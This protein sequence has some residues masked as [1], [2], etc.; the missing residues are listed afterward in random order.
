MRRNVRTGVA[1]DILRLA[2]IGVWAAEPRDV[3]LLHVLFYIRSAGSIEILTDTEGGAQQD[4][5]VGGTQLISLRMAEELGDGRRRAR[6][7]RCG[8]SSPRR[9][10]AS[11]SRPATGS[12]SAPG[13]RSSP[14]PPTL[15]GRIAY[16]PPLP[17]VRD[18]LS[19]RMAQG[20][21]VKCMAVYERPFWRDRG[22]S[23]AVTSVTGPVSVGFDN[24]PPDGSPGVLLGFLEGRAAREAMDL[25]RGRAPARSSPAA[26]RASSG[27]R[28]PTPSTTSIRPGRPR[29]GRAAA[30]AASCRPAPGATT[31]R[32][33][34][35]RSARSTGP[36]P[37]RRRSGTATWTARS[38]PA[39]RPR[40]PSLAQLG[41]S[42][43]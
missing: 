19:Q 29:S 7:L 17:A 4:R 1:R 36:E 20:S 8:G 34:A 21:V 35:I 40:R 25:D 39:A 14:M 5:V 37:R 43:T 31:A 33:C 18:G 6:R 3:S 16:D 9:P 12:R 38:A 41:D 22:L 10:T 32:R 13:G 24:S 2:I 42:V 28:R 11:R 15:A 30:T 26:S 27:P 23:G